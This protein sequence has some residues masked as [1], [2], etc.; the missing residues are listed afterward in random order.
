MSASSAKALAPRSRQ[1]PPGRAHRNRPAWGRAHSC[2][3]CSSIAC[4]TCACACPRR[5]R[6]RSTWAR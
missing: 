5:S 1:A 2:R 3:P 4:T 6:V